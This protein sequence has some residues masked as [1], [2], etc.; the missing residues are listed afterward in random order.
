MNGDKDDGEYRISPLLK[1]EQIYKGIS[2]EELNGKKEVD[3]EMRGQLI[4]D[5]DYVS[6]GYL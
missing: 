1:L 2:L 4:G 6:L 3:F 5:E